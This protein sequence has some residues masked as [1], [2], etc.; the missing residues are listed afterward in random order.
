[1]PDRPARARSSG[2][3]DFVDALV[4][5]LRAVDP[6]PSL[7]RALSAWVCVA[8]L[9]TVIGILV[10]GGLRATALTDLRTPRLAAELTLG[11]AAGIALARAALEAGVPGSPRRRLLAPVLLFGGLWLAVALGALPL[12]GPDAS[13]VGKRAHCFL[14]GLA[15]AVLPGL[16]GL[17]S[18]RRRSLVA[19][20]LTGGL[21]GLAAG[22][23]PALAMTL[24]CLYDPGHALRFHFTPMLVAAA[25]L[26]LRGALRPAPD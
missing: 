17:Q 19:E 12:P 6:A 22:M 4:A 10:L 25:V 15:L 14:E 2:R 18:I 16:V 21:I 9:W 11:A 13:M 20:P 23:L 5:D 26:G 3:P 1:M 8:L 24:A 7:V